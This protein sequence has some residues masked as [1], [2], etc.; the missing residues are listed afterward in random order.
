MSD[1][2]FYLLA[3]VAFIACIFII[4]KVTSCLLKIAIT[5]IILILLAVVYFSYLA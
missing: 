5:I 1:F 4:N 3:L 2:N